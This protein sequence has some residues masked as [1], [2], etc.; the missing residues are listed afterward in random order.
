M[1]WEGRSAGRLAGASPSRPAAARCQVQVP[2]SDLH[3]LAAAEAEQS[4]AAIGMAPHA[5][6]FATAATMPQPEL[7]AQIS[8]DRAAASPVRSVTP[9][10][11]RYASSLTPANPRLVELH[12]G[13]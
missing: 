8:P 12:D 2:P 9:C 6:C 13:R 4:A 5:G 1:S 3:S 7:D 10:A 11:A